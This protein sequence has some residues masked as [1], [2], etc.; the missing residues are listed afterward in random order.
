[1][2]LLTGALLRG[3]RPDLPKERANITAAKL[4]IAC[5]RFDISS[6]LRVAH[7]LAQLA[8]ESGLNPQVENLNYSAARLRAVWPNRFNL[9]TSYQYQYQPEKLANFVYANRLGNGDVSS[10]DGWRYRG[11]GLIQTTGR[12]NY[13]W[14]GEMIG[15]DLVKDPSLL[16]QIGVSCL[17]AGAYWSRRGV[18]RFADADDLDRVTTAVNG[19]INRETNGYYQR[20]KYLRT[21]KYLLGVTK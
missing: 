19:G 17:A 9:V 1:M 5:V 12:E 20:G 14:T 7:L 21:A 10:G 4:E 6:P 11:R 15:F 13:R 8:H 2:T 3:I 16:L 18:N